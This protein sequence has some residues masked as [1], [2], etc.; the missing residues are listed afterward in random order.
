[1][2]YTDNNNVFS[3][4]VGEADS[5]TD[6]AA[7]GTGDVFA[8]EKGQAIAINT[9]G[10]MVLAC[11]GTGI[12]QVPCVGIA[13]KRLVHGE[14]G[15]FVNRG[16]VR[17]ATTLSAPCRVYLSNTPGAVDDSAGDTS[18]FLGRAYVEDDLFYFDPDLSV[19][20]NHVTNS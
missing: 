14:M 3:A 15:T 9:A 13:T 5:Q 18:Q 4:E 12:E 6:S 10:H 19:A 8:I 20:D 2:T 1:M 17:A 7:G 11:A 16:I